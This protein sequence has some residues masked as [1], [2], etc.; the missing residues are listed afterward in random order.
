MGSSAIGR[1]PDRAGF[2]QPSSWLPLVATLAWLLG[3]GTAS[4]QPVVPEVVA[5]APHDPEAF[6]QGLLLFEGVLYESTGLKGRSTLRRVERDTGE[7]LQRIDLPADEFGEG[8]ALVGDRLIQ[9][10]WQNGIAHVYDRESCE[11]LDTFTYDGEG[12]GLCFDGEQLVMSD[13]SSSLFFRDPESFEVLGEVSVIDAAGEAVDQLNELECVGSLVY[14]NV[15]QTDRIVR[16]DKATGRVATEINAESLLSTAERSGTDVL[17]GIAF[18]AATGEFLL[19]G[20]LWP[21]LFTVRFD[22]DPYQVMEGLGTG[23]AGGFGIGGAGGAAGA[24]LDGVG[25]TDDQSTVPRERSASSGCAMG[26]LGRYSTRYS[27]SAFGLALWVLAA[28][29]FRRCRD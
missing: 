18:D 25:A 16:I 17:N 7:V 20:K 3:S 27:T 6:T 26:P 5:E 10:T 23:G 21:K 28:R 13:G 2:A 22:F 1:V 11:E 9:L 29:A 24:M 19:T 15:W 8:L 12:W 4:A 14:A